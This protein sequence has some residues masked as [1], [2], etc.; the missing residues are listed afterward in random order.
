V[1]GAISGPGAQRADFHGWRLHEPSA[2]I[3]GLPK[4]S[5]AVPYALPEML[6]GLNQSGLPDRS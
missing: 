6:R 5:C 4:P 1:F 2:G 3:F